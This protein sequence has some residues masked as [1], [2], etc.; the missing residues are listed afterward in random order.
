[1]HPNVSLSELPDKSWRWAVSD[2]LTAVV[3]EQG[4]TPTE[5]EAIAAANIAL[6]RVQTGVKLKAR[7]TD[8]L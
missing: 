7:P 5:A 4:V 8:R 2:G 3:I 1:M 6:D